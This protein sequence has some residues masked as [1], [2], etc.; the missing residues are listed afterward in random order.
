MLLSIHIYDGIYSHSIGRSGGAASV[1][2]SSDG[3]FA[4]SGIAYNSIKVWDVSTGKIIKTLEGSAVYLFGVCG[5]W[6]V[7][8]I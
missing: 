5:I 7:N 2:I 4:A 3:H 6:Y 8:G 1:V